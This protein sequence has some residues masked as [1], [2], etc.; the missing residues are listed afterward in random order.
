MLQEEGVSEWVHSG[1]LRYGGHSE[2]GQGLAS[3]AARWMDAGVYQE[4]MRMHFKEVA[5]VQ[6]ATAQLQ[7]EDAIARK[8]LT[9]SLTLLRD[10]VKLLHESTISIRN[11][12]ERLNDRCEV[13]VTQLVRLYL[14]KIGELELDAVGEI[15]RTYHQ[16]EPVPG[17]FEWGVEWD[18]VLFVPEEGDRGSQ[19]YLIEAKSWLE[20]CH[21]T[22]MTNRMLR[23]VKFLQLC[24]R[25]DFREAA[26]KHLLGDKP[27]R[28][29]RIKDKRYAALCS[30]WSQY[31]SAT[32][33][34]GVIGGIGFTQAMLARAHEDGLLT[35]AP[36]HGLYEVSSPLGGLRSAKPSIAASSS[37]QEQPPVTVTILEAE[38]REVVA[39]LEVLDPNILE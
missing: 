33:V 6:A 21:V 23:T 34:Y 28:A 39:E 7:K 15:P 30:A 31:S 27:T 4:Q 17:W 13:L 16:I 35:V 2:A 14:K 25:Q 38:L 9:H 20:S 37:S 26:A 18:G 3:T 22:G 12:Q 32:A 19:L 24:S 11:W 29:T 1:R 8:Q 10:S 5:A 36:A